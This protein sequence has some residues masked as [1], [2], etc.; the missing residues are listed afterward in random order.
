MRMPSESQVGELLETVLSPLGQFAVRATRAMTPR[1][2]RPLGRMRT[3]SPTARSLMAGGSATFVLRCVGMMLA[4]AGALLAARVLGAHDYGQYA[5]A[6]SW[7][8]LLQ[9]VTVIGCD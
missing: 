7:A 5:W 2:R 4:F 9:L 8:T 1:L 6:Y 3:A